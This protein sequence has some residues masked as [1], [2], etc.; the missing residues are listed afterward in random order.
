MTRRDVL[1]VAAA[2]VIAPWSGSAGTADPPKP[3]MAPPPNV[4]APTDALK[5]LLEGN[6]RYVKNELKERD[7]SAGRAARVQAQYPFAAILSCADSRVTPA[8][9]AE[10]L[11]RQEDRH[12]GRRVRSRQRQDY[13]RVTQ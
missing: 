4:I 9:R 1:A 2:T 3:G 13:A 7:F 5:R 12:R 6:E 8:D 10:V 11:R